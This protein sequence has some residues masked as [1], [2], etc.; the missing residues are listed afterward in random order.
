[1]FASSNAPRVRRSWARVPLPAESPSGTETGSG[2]GKRRSPRR[3]GR[4]LIHLDIEPVTEGYLEIIDAKSGHRVVTTIEL[5]SVANKRPG[6]GRRL[7][8]KNGR[9]I[10]RPAQPG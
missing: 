1:M 7:Y 4:C 9:I 10:R 8:L 2:N 5:L 3:P 6:K